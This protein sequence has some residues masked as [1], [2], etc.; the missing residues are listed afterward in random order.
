MS[1]LAVTELARP[2]TPSSAR[3]VPPRRTPVL[4]IG[5]VGP[6]NV[7]RA[8]LRQLAEA[9]PRIAAARACE[10]R[11]HAL[12]NRTRMALAPGCLDGDDALARLADGVTVDLDAFA[13]HLR[14]ERP[15]HSLIVDCSGADAIAEH[16]PRWLAAGIHVVTPSKHAGSGPLAR[17]RA[18]AAARAAS[19]AQF[20][21]EATVG[22]GLPVIQTLRG[23][24]DTGDELTGIEGVLSGTL[25]W[26]CNRYDGSRPFSE[27]VRQAHA[28]GYTEPDPRDDL[29]GLDVA[30][31]LVILAREAG[32]EL[33][34]ADVQVESL[35]PQALRELPRDDFMA[36]LEEF[37]APMRTRLDAAQA[38]GRSLRYLARID[39][40]RAQVGLAAP[41]AD[42]ASLHTR[43]TD[44]VIVFHTRRYADN[45][46]VVQGPGAGPEVT[47]AGVFGD[48]LM[49]AQGL[50]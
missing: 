36:R 10:L 34:L 15:A 28:L 23:L 4:S 16:Y 26:L 2:A 1:V 35:V 37:D 29:S 21:Y 39:R 18:I 46:L 24:L 49:I 33:S 22:A 13:A 47:A 48:I 3:R 19:G 9:V 12:A 7:G 50:R 8:L 27:L 44:N 42:H 17:H 38:S 14:R 20:R 45:P 25:A 30:R 32:R 40:E 6:G 31:K 5:L 41:D 11:L 43:L